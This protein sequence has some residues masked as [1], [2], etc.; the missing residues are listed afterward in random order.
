MLK[1]KEKFD[2]ERYAETPNLWDVTTMSGRPVRILC[3]DGGSE[4]F[5]VI[6]VINGQPHR[7]TKDGVE[8]IIFY[9]QDNLQMQWVDELP[10]INILTEELAEKYDGKCYVDFDDNYRIEAFRFFKNENGLNMHYVGTDGLRVSYNWTDFDKI[11]SEGME[12][13]FS[14][15]YINMIE[16][17]CY[18]LKEITKEEFDE[19]VDIVEQCKDF[20]NDRHIWLKNKQAELGIYPENF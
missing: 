3:T 1:E 10:A 8:D 9:H 14:L 17:N 4:E 15:S 13:T 18:L 6:G 5:P 16:E 7:Y 12:N 20:S 19:I 2:K 11:P